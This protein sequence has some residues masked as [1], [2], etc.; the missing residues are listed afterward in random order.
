MGNLLEVHTEENAP[1]DSPPAT[2]NCL[3]FLIE[4][5]DITPP[6]SRE[7]CWQA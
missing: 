7:E 1:P 4:R 2:P 3:Q 5:Q 6:L